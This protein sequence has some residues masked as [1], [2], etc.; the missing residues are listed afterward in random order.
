MN[1]RT[2]ILLAALVPVLAGCVG[3]AAV[4]VGAGA[5]MFTDR[6]MP[7]TIV[8]DEGI[9]LRAAG[10]INERFGDRVHVNVTS[11]NRMALLTGE[12]PDAA[13]RAEVEK[14]VAAV[15]NLKS[16]SNELQIGPVS[17]LSNRSNDVYLTSKVKA[18]FIDASQFSANNVKVV[19]ENGVVYLLGLATQR[20]VDAAVQIAR[21]TGG[22]RKVV[23]VFELISDAEA[24]RLDPQPTAN[25]PAAQPTP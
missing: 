2:L 19:T 25:K 18:R 10:R 3:A 15:P 1:R 16:I 9:E 12:V 17:T 14:L 22:V 24:R 23:R 11:Y 5:L 4:G 13:A 6:R 8:T 7:E 20:E 21:T